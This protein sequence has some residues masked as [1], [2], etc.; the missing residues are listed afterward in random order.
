[1]ITNVS[2]VTVYV[3]DQDEAKRFYCDVLGFVE[4]TDI[5]MG[6]GFRWVTVVH[7]EQPG[8]VGQRSVPQQQPGEIH[9]EEAASMGQ[10][11]NPEGEQ[12]E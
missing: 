9:C 4:G 2:L 1:M 7:P 12:A 10:R 11:G 5:T 6:E 3:T 8:V